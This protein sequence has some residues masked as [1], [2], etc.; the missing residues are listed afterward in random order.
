MKAEAVANIFLA[1]RIWPNENPI[2]QRISN[3]REKDWQEVVGV[4]CRF[5]HRRYFVAW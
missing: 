1:Q 4:V 3:P 2:E 5:R